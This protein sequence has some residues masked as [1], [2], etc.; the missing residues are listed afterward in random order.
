MRNSRK[1]RPS[2]IAEWLRSGGG[3][4]AV[5]LIFCTTLFVAAAIAQTSISYRIDT[6]AGR[7]IGDGG[8]ASQAQLDFPTGLAVDASGNIYIADSEN[9][10]I[11]KLTPGDS[12]TPPTTATLPDKPPR[13]TV[14]AATPYSLTVSWDEPENSGAAITGY[15]VR[16]RDGGS[17]NAFTDAQHQGTARTAT[18]AGLIPDTLYEVQVRASNA[19]GT[20]DWSESGEGKTDTLLTGDRIYYFPHLAVGASW[21]TTITL[22]NY[23][24]EEVTCQTDFIS[25][26]GSPLPVSF[27]SL[28]SVI[29]RTDVLAP[30]GSIHEQTDVELSARL[31]AGWAR[32][33]LL[34]AGE[35][36]PSVS[37]ARQRW[38]T[39]GGSGS[40][41]GDRSGHPLR[42]LCRTGGRPG[43]DRRGLCQPFLHGGSRHLYCQGRGWTD[44]GQ[45]CSDSVARWA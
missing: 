12:S 3:V 37:S 43:W 14:S 36:Q 18:P 5:K 35:G 16:Y 6:I 19:A 10:L 27:P 41:C 32:G 33:H 40:Q 45:R 7:G 29:S 25:D 17:G 1:T 8:A 42:H 30:G 22:I 34:G 38:H 26:H 20:G 4:R 24:P 28:G 15:D 9:H 31:A 2:Q 21:Q 13:P 11:R 23:S 39:R 44:A